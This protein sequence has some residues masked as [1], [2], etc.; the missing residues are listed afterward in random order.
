VGVRAAPRRRDAAR[1]PLDSWGNL[2]FA[3]GL[4]LVLVGSRTDGLTIV[5]T[6]SMLMALIAAGASLMRG[7][8]YVHE[9]EPRRV[10]EHDRDDR[11]VGPFGARLDD[12]PAAPGEA[13]VLEERTPA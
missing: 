10:G 3:V 13:P 4:V 7:A 12:G 8:N 9:D 1:G 11:G 5:F 6:A 2:T